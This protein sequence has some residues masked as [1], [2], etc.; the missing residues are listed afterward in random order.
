MSTAAPSQR[1]ARR[2]GGWGLVALLLLFASFIA[3]LLAPSALQT[4][5]P[6]DPESYGPSGA[7]ALGEVLRDQGVE[8]VVVRDRDAVVERLEETGAES[9]D[10]TLALPA[11]EFLSDEAVR[12]LAALSSR[13]VFLSESEQLLEIFALG[14]WVSGPTDA[15]AFDLAGDAEAD[16]VAVD[17][18]A[19]G[20]GL[21]Q[22]AHVGGIGAETFFSPAEDVAGCFL[23]E[24]GSAAVLL[25]ERD[26]ASIALLEGTRLLSNEHLGTRGNAAL[27]LAL[28]GQGERVIWYVPSANDVEL[29][30]DQ[31]TLGDLTPGWVTPAIALL[32]LTGIAAGVWRGRRFGPLVE[33]TLPVTV[34]ASE[35]LLGRAKLNARAAN[36]QHA[37]RVLRGGSLRRL[38]R[39]VGLSDEARAE[40]VV[41][42]LVAR[43][44]V[45]ALQLHRLLTGP[46]PQDDAGLLD[47]ARD[48]E[49]LEA[50][51]D[52]SADP[53]EAAASRTAIPASP[54]PRK[55]QP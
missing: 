4:P 7:R 38:A 39:R 52:R 29:G 55:E 5:D 31:R 8:V 14:E 46:L 13:T 37:A 36:A 41:G 20:C 28:L 51:L 53:T 19:P 3:V 22:F 30:E 54:P 27:G 26:G 50:E 34:R 49:A 21:P 15:T 35:T 42:S 9:G 12:S 45:D 32:L 33:E 18:G 10:T 48:L 25:A 1:R 2:V 17:A 16:V 40:E 44:G 23:D 11:P 47:F 6:L 24:E 43:P